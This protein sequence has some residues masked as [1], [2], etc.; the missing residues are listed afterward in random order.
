MTKP[1]YQTNEE[2][3]IKKRL[4]VIDYFINNPKLYPYCYCE[5][6][7]IF[8]NAGSKFENSFSWECEDCFCFKEVKL[9]DIKVRIK[10]QL[11]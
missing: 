7:F 6:E 9:D 2:N 3:R 4:I 5:M 1:E 10:D 11:L 8:S